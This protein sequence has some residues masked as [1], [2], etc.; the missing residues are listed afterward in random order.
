MNVAILY[1]GGKDSTFAIQHAMEKGWSIKYLI[2]I[3]P[4]RKDCYLF[5][6]ATVEHTK[7]LA[8]AMDIPHIYAKCSVANPKEEAEIVRK[9]VEKQQKIKSMTVDAVVLGGTGLQE[10]QLRSIQNA[11]MPMHIEVFASHAGEEHDIVMEEMLNRGYEIMITQIAS[12]GLNRWIGQ[13]LT[14][15]NF[16]QFRIDSMKYGFHVGGEGGYYDTLVIDAP[17]FSKRIDVS[18]IKMIMEDEFCGHVELNKY[19]IVNKNKVEV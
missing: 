7:E 8:K 12:D 15:E 17:I 4:T 16:R 9:I 2:S 14:K 3:K 11:L 13:K 6:Y 19:R 10:T 1:S 18:Q 5:H